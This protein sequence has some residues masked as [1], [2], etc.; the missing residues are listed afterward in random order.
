MSNFEYGLSF[1]FQK[2]YLIFTEENHLILNSDSTANL[3]I[4]ILLSLYERLTV[5]CQSSI[6]HRWNYIYVCVCVYVEYTGL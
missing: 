2:V 4:A 1:I 6:D 5:Y 3:D